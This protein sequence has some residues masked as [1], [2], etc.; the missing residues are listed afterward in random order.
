MT[1]EMAPIFFFSS[2][3]EFHLSGLN[4][5]TSHLDMQKIQIIGFLFE[6]IRHWQSEVETKK[7]YKQLF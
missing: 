2:T 7:I 3:V 5:K 1:S 6:N 4:G